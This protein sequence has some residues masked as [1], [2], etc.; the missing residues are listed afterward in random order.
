[1]G[2]TGHLTQWPPTEAW[3]RAI[4]EKETQVAV[5]WAI[6]VCSAQQETPLAIIP[7]AG[8]TFLPVD[9]PLIAVP[10]GG[11]LDA[12]QVRTGVGFGKTLN[13]VNLTSQY[14]GK[15]AFL[16]LIRTPL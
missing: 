11:G 9:Y 15:K 1:M 10:D 7:A 4:K 8:P 14:R 12:G 3:C 6:H 13:P 16:L 2:F 5:P